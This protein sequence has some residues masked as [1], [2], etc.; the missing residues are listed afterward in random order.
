MNIEE[1]DFLVP[2]RV[3]RKTF[4]WWSERKLYEVVNVG[5]RVGVFSDD[6]DFYDEQSLYGNHYLK[7]YHEYSFT[8]IKNHISLENE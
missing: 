4:D 8:V 3:V 7:E 5:G 2:P 6:G 1:G